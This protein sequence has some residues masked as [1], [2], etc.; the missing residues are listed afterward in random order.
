MTKEQQTSRGKPKKPRARKCLACREWFNPKEQGITTCSVDCG[1]LY[2]KSNFTKQ[3][4]R[5]KRK[6]K[7]KLRDE[8]AKV[9]MQDCYR[10]AQAIGRFH[11]YLSGITKC[12]TCNIPLITQEQVDGGH[13]KKKNVYS[14]IK[15][16]TLQIHPQ[17]VNCN[18]YNGGRE[19]EYRLFMIDRYGLEKVEWLES[20]KG[21]ITKKYTAEYLRKYKKIMGKRLRVLEKRLAS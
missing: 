4:V 3:K 16:Y 5:E 19:D 20:H 6:A 7:K 2:G 15:L 10:I 21:V 9:L 18:Q 14:A 13:F 11:G 8:D 1:I 17:C 12:V